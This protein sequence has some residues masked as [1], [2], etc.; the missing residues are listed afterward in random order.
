MPSPVYLPSV[1]AIKL[2]TAAMT[3]ITAVRAKI[4]APVAVAIPIVAITLAVLPGKAAVG[5]TVAAILVAGGYAAVPGKTVVVSNVAVMRVVPAPAVKRGKPA[6]VPTVASVTAVTRRTCAVAL[7][8]IS[9]VTIRPAMMIP[10]KSAAETEMVMCAIL[11]RRAAA[12]MGVVNP[13]GSAVM[14]SVVRTAKFAA[15]TVPVP[16]RVNFL[17]QRAIATRRTVRTTSVRG[18]GGTP[19][20]APITQQECTPETIPTVV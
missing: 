4:A 7:P 14:A 10:R 8:G 9:A 12:L 19:V 18:V 6:V 16:N 13:G 11:I 20:F 5:A 3:T 1:Q 17:R 2:A 15:M